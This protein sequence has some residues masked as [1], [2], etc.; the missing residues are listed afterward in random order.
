MSEKKIEHTHNQ[1]NWTYIFFFFCEN[2][3]TDILALQ[4]MK[5]IGFFATPNHDEHCCIVNPER[6]PEGIWKAGTLNEHAPRQNWRGGNAR[7]RKAEI[8]NMNR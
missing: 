1:A 6:S 3:Y 8:F 4:E 2:K 7:K 5:K